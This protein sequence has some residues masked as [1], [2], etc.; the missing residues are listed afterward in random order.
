MAVMTTATIMI[1]NMRNLGQEET[2]KTGLLVRGLSPGH[3]PGRETE[4]GAEGGGLCSRDDGAIHGVLDLQVVYRL[5]ELLKWHWGKG[6]LLKV[7]SD[8]V[9]L[10]KIKHSTVLYTF[11]KTY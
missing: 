1:K 6:V 7:F 2:A 5:V 8:K 3:E 10:Q 4:P 11:R 9:F